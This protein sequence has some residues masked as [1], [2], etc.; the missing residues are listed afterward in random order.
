MFE[1]KI[2]TV[3]VFSMAIAVLSM[4]GC[5]S[6]REKGASSDT[7]FL[8]DHNH[9]PIANAKYITT[10]EDTSKS[11]TLSGTDM[12]GDTLTYKITQ[13][14]EHGAISGI[15]PNV[16]YTPTANYHGPDN[17]TFNVND[18]TVD[19]DIATVRIMVKPVNDAPTVNAGKDQSVNQGTEVILD[20]IAS[21]PDGTIV[22]YKWTENLTVLSNH[23]SFVKSDFTV[24]EHILMV[25]VTDNEGATATDKVKITV[26]ADESTCWE[27]I[28]NPALDTDPSKS[29]E[30]PTLTIG[31]QANANIYAGWTEGTG[32]DQKYFVK[33][34][35]SG[36]SWQVIGE[37]LA[38]SDPRPG[39]SRVILKVDPNDGYPYAYYKTNSEKIRLD[40]YNHSSNTWE[41]K[42]EINPSG[43]NELLNLIG[44]YDMTINKNGNPVFVF[45][46]LYNDDYSLNVMEYNGTACDFKTPILFNQGEVPSKP[47]IFED[48]SLNYIA[49]VDIA[50]NNEDYHTRIYRFSGTTWTNIGYLESNASSRQIACRSA[51]TD[52]NGDL[53]IA[54]VEKSASG[55]NAY[56]PHIFVKKIISNQYGYHINTLGNEIN[57]NIS[58]DIAGGLDAHNNDDKQCISIATEVSYSYHYYVAWQHKSGQNRE[59]HTLK[60]DGSSWSEAFAPLKDEQSLRVP[61]III[62]QDR[63]MNIS[64]MYDSTPD[65]DDQDDIKVYRCNTPVSSGGED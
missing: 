44:K 29:A 52:N 46:T 41:N 58:V 12:D 31:W 49:T 8:D 36:T 4:T 27:S 15:A 47:S 63:R 56:N 51:V 48:M 20:A 60:Y 64:L 40:K 39:G 26:N 61:T 33:Q 6:D 42:C 7:N 17:F 62:D 13:N 28:S 9:V 25:T 10:N 30:L 45:M 65:T 16:T 22:S 11:I 5:S 1:K 24:G 35:I 38:T 32:A 34:Y 19:S 59:I 2:F 3:V 53:V 21:D 54:Y 57:N 37:A 23:K 55:H 50:Q 14:P 43:G 18:G